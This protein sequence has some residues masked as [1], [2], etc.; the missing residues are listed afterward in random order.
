MVPISRH[1][2]A[3]DEQASQ[4]SEQEGATMW[5]ARAAAEKEIQTSPPCERYR[6]A[7]H[8]RYIAH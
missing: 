3:V 1:G 4:F 8:W 6:I 5:M 7:M 2:T